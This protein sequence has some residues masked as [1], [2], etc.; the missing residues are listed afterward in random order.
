MQIAMNTFIRLLIT[1]FL[2]TGSLNT[3]AQ[4]EDV[5]ENVNRDKEKSDSHKSNDYDDS[6]SLF[7]NCLAAFFGNLLLSTFGSAQNSA[8]QKLDYYPERISLE[9]LSTFGTEFTSRTHDFQ[10]GIRYNRGIFATEFRYNN[11]KDATGKLKSLNWLIA[12]IRLPIG[13]FKLDY[14]IGFIDLPDLDKRYFNS[15]FGFDWM[16]HPWGVNIKSDY[17]WTQKTNLGPRYLNRYSLRIDY[18]IYNYRKLHLS[19]IVEYVYLDYF[20]QTNFSVLS[21]GM[22]VRLF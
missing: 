19:P 5:K 10:A 18:N 4:V 2:L 16:I 15:V 20:D 13:S 1:F 22:M 17:Q 12:N 3:Y 21:I 6:E 8:M 7:D 14:G 11:L 9:V